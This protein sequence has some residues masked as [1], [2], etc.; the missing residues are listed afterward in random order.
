MGTTVGPFKRTKGHV[1]ETE[2]Y[3]KR[4]KTTSGLH[5]EYYQPGTE[6]KD[7]K[8]K[9]LAT[10]GT[11]SSKKGGSP[12]GSPAWKE[13]EAVLIKEWSECLRACFGPAMH[14]G[15]RLSTEG[16]RSCFDC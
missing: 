7:K 4:E 5:L 14:K 10:K 1:D 6:I 8:K 15:P 3:R 12:D 11:S 9:L 2:D 13:T 16:N